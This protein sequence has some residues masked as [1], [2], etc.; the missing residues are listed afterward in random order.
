MSAERSERVDNATRFTAFEVRAGL[1]IPPT[2]DV[3]RARRAL[4]KAERQ[5]LISNSLK[6]AIHLVIDIDIDVVISPEPVASQ[7]TGK[8]RDPPSRMT[9]DA[10]TSMNTKWPVVVALSAFL[11]IAA[12]SSQGPALSR[13][14]RDKLTHMQKILEA[15]VTSD[16]VSLET[17]SRELERLTGDPR[18]M[19]LKSPSTRGK[20]PDLFGR[21]RTFI[22]QRRNA[23]WNRL[24]RHT[25]PLPSNASS[26]I[27][28]W[29]ENAWRSEGC[30]M[31]RSDRPSSG[32][33]LGGV[34][35]VRTQI[36]LVFEPRTP[37]ADCSNVL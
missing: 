7:P 21:F 30:R 15:M 12:S 16:W 5:C 35:I 37:P 32:L 19:V 2:T 31:A 26:A 22:G 33:W 25:S 27:D 34:V 9:S 18:W 14:M 24:P 8:G 10:S 20:V 4:E 6:G 23:T 28:I 17:H 29:R 36:R 11:G 3:G 1:S 13:V